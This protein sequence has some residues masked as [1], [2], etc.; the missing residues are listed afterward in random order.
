MSASRFEIVI[1]DGK[2]SGIDKAIF[3]KE[4]EALEDGRYR[5]GFDKKKSKCTRYRYYFDA[6][7]S[8]ALPAAAKVFHVIEKGQERP[9]RNTVE[10]H[11]IVKGIFNPVVAINME[12]GE[13]IIK[14]GTTTSMSDSEFISE[15]TPK[16]LEYFA[17]HPFFVEFVDFEEWGQL[18]S[19]GMWHKIKHMA[20]TEL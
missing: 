18:Y 1:K 11:E 17:S 2:M 4:F 6:V 20:T 10:L 15:Y 12:T 19:E 5:I 3:R 16:V 14:G 9:I 13:Q 7:L 8:F